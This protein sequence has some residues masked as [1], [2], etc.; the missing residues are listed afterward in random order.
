MAVSGGIV[1]R[2]GAA[3]DGISCKVAAAVTAGKLVEAVTAG[4]RRVQHAQANSVVVV[5]V[6]LQTASAAE[7]EITIATEGFV[8][9]TASGAVTNGARIKAGA[10]GVAVAI[11]ADGDPRLA[12]AIAYEDGIDTGTF[13]AKLTL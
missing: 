2:Y 5:G 1:E 3:L 4:S 7:D 10:A 13:L 8:M 6:A 9:L 12:V 11:A